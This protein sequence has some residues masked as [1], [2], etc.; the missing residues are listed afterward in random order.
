MNIS[1]YLPTLLRKVTA[2]TLI[3]QNVAPTTVVVT[4]ELIPDIYL[5]I[6]Y[7]LLTYQLI[8]KMYLYTMFVLYT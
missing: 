3:Q 1:S 4:G 7:V 2:T 8:I 6:F 5:N